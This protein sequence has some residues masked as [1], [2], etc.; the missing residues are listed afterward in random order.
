MISITI[1]IAQN[2]NGKYI[3]SIYVAISFVFSLKLVS[4]VFQ[5]GTSFWTDCRKST[6]ANLSS[7]AVLAFKTRS[8]R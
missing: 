1:L 7:V 4:F 6:S 3:I 8:M 5:S 2:K